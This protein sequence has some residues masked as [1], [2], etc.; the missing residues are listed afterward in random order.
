MPSLLL[1]L[2]L[3][4]RIGPGDGAKLRA[5]DGSMASSSTVTGWRHIAADAATAPADTEAF[6]L[7]VQV[8]YSTGW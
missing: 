2:L 3:P 8:L 7:H 4:E 6:N 1:L 5:V